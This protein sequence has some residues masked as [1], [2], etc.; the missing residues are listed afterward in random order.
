MSLSLAELRKKNHLSASSVGQYLACGLAFKFSKIENLPPEFRPD[1]LELGSVIHRVL[2]DFNNE[3]KEGNILSLVVL[4]E[5]FIAYWRAAAQ[6]RTDIVYKEGNDFQSL[7][8]QGKNLL[9]VYYESRPW[10]EFSVI[11]V[12]EALQFSIE[13]LDVPIIGVM[14]LVEADSSGTIVIVDFKS[15]GKAYST[16][17]VDNSLQLT[18]Y[19]MGAKANGFKNREILLRFDCLI[20]TKKPKFEQYYTTRASSAE[21]RT[22]KKLIEVLNGIS[23][24]I[25]IPTDEG[26]QC[27][28]CGYK[29]Y[30]DE[31]FNS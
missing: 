10:E 22:A 20:K 13:G 23:K 9:A 29:R 24:G 31:W 25:F 19:Q 18:L 4:H 12:E 5:K 14:D 11:A 3:R 26:W 1:S 6:K 30:C 15:S 2:K 17:D 8:E 27:K 28:G 21:R 7:L 16:A